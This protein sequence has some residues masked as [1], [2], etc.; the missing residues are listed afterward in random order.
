MERMNIAV[1]LALTAAAFNAGND[2]LYRKASLISRN[3]GPLPFYFVSSAASSAIALGFDI[4]NSGGPGK[5][6]FET[7]D[8]FYG[9]IL[10]VLSFVT[11][12]LYLMSFSGDNTSVSVTIYRMNLIPG[13]ILAVIFIGEVISLK[14]GLAI[15]FCVLS[16][17][18]LGSFRFGRLKDNRHLLLSIGALLSGGVL[19]FINKSAVIH[20]GNALNLLFVRFLV[21]SVL[22]GIFIIHKKSFKFDKKALKYAIL[23]GLLLMIAIYLILEAFKT[24]DVALVL[25]IT[26]LSFTLIVI[27]SWIFFKEDMN[28]KKLSGIILAI[29][30]VLLMN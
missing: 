25:P 30:S 28:V 3:T 9:G 10:G 11:Y 14:R 27:A 5:L 15:I 20:G 1:T 21:V 22:T 24:G 19:N 23:S 7:V 8:L 4:F 2:L 12:I 17:L 16:V 13:I 18:L 26:Q 6:H 29:G